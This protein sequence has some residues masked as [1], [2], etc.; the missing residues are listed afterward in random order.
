M[1]YMRFVCTLLLVALCA[2]CALT[3]DADPPAPVSAY[4]DAGIGLY[5]NLGR[6]NPNFDFDGGADISHHRLFGEV[7]AGVD[8][9]NGVG[10]GNGY[11]VRTHGLIFYRPPGK[12]SVGGGFYFS[13]FATSVFSEHDLWP[14]AGVLYENEWLRANVQ[15][16]FPGSNSNFHEQGPS[17]D[18]RFR[19]T[20]GFYVR[21]RVALLHYNDRVQTP[22]KG[23]FGSEASF[24]VLYVFRQRQ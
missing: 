19:L 7:E 15:Y 11:T 6:S 10:T 21:E 8:T 23:H 1:G 2:S 13:R 16:L 9:A 22:P 12:W 14:S 24:G 5:G 18:A 4:A 20:G 17:L 3:Q